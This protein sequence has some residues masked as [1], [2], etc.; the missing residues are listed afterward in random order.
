MLLHVHIQVSKSLGESLL[1][2]S[3]NK[4][5][6]ENFMLRTYILSVYK[7]PLKQFGEYFCG[8]ELRMVNILWNTSKVTHLL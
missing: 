3:E 4:F 1:P 6:Q 2:L 7:V 5:Y 8:D